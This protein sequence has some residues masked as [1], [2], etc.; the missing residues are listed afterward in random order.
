MTTDQ[1]VAFLLFAVVA[2]ATPGLVVM[3]D[4]HIEPHRVAA[5]E[6]RC[7]VC[8]DGGLSVGQPEVVACDRECRRDL[9]QRGDQEFLVAGRVPQRAVRLRRL[10]QRLLVARLRGHHPA[11]SLQPTQAEG[12]QRRNG[13]A[14]CPIDCSHPAVE[15]HD[16]TPGAPSLSPA[17]R[18]GLA[19]RHA[20]HTEATA[21]GC[22]TG[23]PQRPCSRCCP[24]SSAQTPTS[25]ACSGA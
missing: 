21:S 6:D 4:R 7:R 2:A 16:T 10:A 5:G 25:S 3:E 1:A 8:R 12:I 18:L 13:C 14:S 23:D 22:F 9:S 15:D 20:Q 24:P 11:C 19:P 17:P